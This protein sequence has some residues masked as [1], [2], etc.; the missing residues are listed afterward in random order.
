MASAARVPPV[1]PFRSS[2]PSVIEDAK[3]IQQ[4]FS[5]DKGRVVPGTCIPAMFYTKSAD[6]AP[7]F[8][9]MI[10]PISD[11]PDTHVK[12]E[13]APVAGAVQGPL[14]PPVHTV[15]EDATA[16]LPDDDEDVFQTADNHPTPSCKE[17]PA[18]VFDAAT[19]LLGARPD[20]L[21]RGF[22]LRQTPNNITNYISENRNKRQC[23]LMWSPN[24]YTLVMGEGYRPLFGRYIRTPD[25]SWI[26]FNLALLD[27]CIVFNTKMLDA[28]HVRFSPLFVP[29][30]AG[31]PNYWARNVT[32]WAGVN[33]TVPPIPSGA[34]LPFGRLPGHLSVKLSKK[35]P[36]GGAGSAADT[37]VCLFPVTP[38]VDMATDTAAASLAQN[39]TL[40]SDYPQHPIVQGHS[41]FSFEEPE[42]ANLS[43]QDGGVG[44]LM[45]RMNAKELGFQ[46]EAE[47]PGQPVVL[48]ARCVFG[49][50]ALESV[51]QQRSVVYNSVMFA[52]SN[53]P[54]S[55]TGKSFVTLDTSHAGQTAVDFGTCFQLHAA[56]FHADSTSAMNAVDVAAQSELLVTR[57]ILRDNPGATFDAARKEA[58]FRTKLMAEH[59]TLLSTAL[60]IDVQIGTLIRTFQ[61]DEFV[62]VCAMDKRATDLATSWH[63]VSAAS[64]VLFNMAPPDVDAYGDKPIVIFGFIVRVHL[65]KACTDMYVERSP[66]DL[67]LMYKTVSDY[68]TRFMWDM[69]LYNDQLSVT[70][71]RKET[72]L[73]L[74]TDKAP[75]ELNVHSAK[76]GLPAR[77]TTTSK[78]RRIRDPH[79][80]LKP[81]TVDT[82]D[83]ALQVPATAYAPHMDR[84]AANTNPLLRLII[85]GPFLPSGIPGS[86]VAI[87]RPGTKASSTHFAGTCHSWPVH[88]GYVE[89]IIMTPLTAEFPYGLFPPEVTEEERRAAVTLLYAPLYNSVQGQI[90][91]LDGRWRNPDFRRREWETAYG[92]S[93]SLMHRAMMWL[94]YP[95][96]ASEY[97]SPTAIRIWDLKQRCEAVMQFMARWGRIIRGV[98]QNRRRKVRDD[99]KGV[100]R[101][102]VAQVGRRVAHAPIA[103]KYLSAY[104]GFAENFIVGEVTRRRS[105]LMDSHS[106][107]G[108]VTA[109]GVGTVLGGHTLVDDSLFYEEVT[110]SNIHAD[111]IRFDS[112]YDTDFPEFPE[113]DDEDAPE[114]DPSGGAYEGDGGMGS[115]SGLGEVCTLGSIFPKSLAWS[116]SRTAH[117]S[118]TM[119]LIGSLRS[120]NPGVET[121]NLMAEIQEYETGRAAPALKRH[122]M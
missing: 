78:C 7:S 61:P 21:P 67:Y 93:V 75:G 37:P 113:E 31:D 120:C 58:R 87:Y 24:Q 72:L 107:P 101:N 47:Q 68:G 11:F 104:N 26:Y 65:G 85:R 4:R 10:V 91:S 23:K 18:T 102:Y 94:M 115:F 2:S 90:W 39:Y 36:V 88:A 70:S 42:N 77:T 14:A 116:V 63:N 52:L 45:Y 38:V 40:T 105:D 59:P 92:V 82:T 30:P 44:F 35:K 1:P 54:R 76:L 89:K 79:P 41:V 114:L 64:P 46:N 6:E 9:A 112:I 108:A 28:P 96:F 100:T 99:V 110:T 22:H 33:N 27:Y 20:T 119:A 122:C 98:L 81:F 62:D 48:Y 111:A 109:G 13:T 86:E 25:G 17:L 57:W 55:S 74:L 56:D 53:V 73:S 32:D 16:E 118:G 106:N 103:D 8:S 5:T 117:S 66:P 95:A 83:E 84:D 121:L 80:A 3:R 71:T 51:A 19:E 97:K 69:M 29:S 15:E 50:L 12:C 49:D 43:C 34:C 60:P